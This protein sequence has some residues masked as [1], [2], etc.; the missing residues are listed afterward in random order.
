MQKIRIEPGKDKTKIYTPYN[1]EFV[2]RIKTQIKGAKWNGSAWVI[3]AETAGMAKEIIAEV[4]GEAGVEINSSGEESAAKAVPDKKLLPERREELVAERERL[5]RRLLE[6]DALLML[7]E[8]S[9]KKFVDAEEV[10]EDWGVSM[11]QAYRIVQNMNREIKKLYP[12]AI[13]V[14]GKVSRPYYERCCLTD[15]RAGGKTR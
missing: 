5:R 11:S 3:P 1:A 6:I 15:I 8:G 10:A 14:R 4:Y 9:E 13:I 12:D 2:S 7:D